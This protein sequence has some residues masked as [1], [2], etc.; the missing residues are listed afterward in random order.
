M[1][2]TP[3]DTWQWLWLRCMLC[4]YYTVLLHEVWFHRAAIHRSFGTAID[5]ILTLLSQ[6]RPALRGRHERCFHDARTQIMAKLTIPIVRALLL[7]VAV[8]IIW[9]C[10]SDENHWTDRKEVNMATR[11]F[12]AFCVGWLLTL[13]S[14]RPIFYD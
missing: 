14:P 9:K 10:E 1:S 8:I 11:L 4:V 13:V 7:T 5:T 6:R 12:V 2:D 3:V